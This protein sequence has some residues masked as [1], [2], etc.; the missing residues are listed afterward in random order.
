M[1]IPYSVAGI[2]DMDQESATLS[3]TTPR[4]S[5]CYATWIFRSPSRLFESVMYLIHIT[6]RFPRESPPKYDLEEESH[7]IKER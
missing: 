7:L 2:N 4:V 5:K 6:E 1:N 3:S